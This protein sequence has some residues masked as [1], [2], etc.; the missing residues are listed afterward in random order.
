MV[1]RGVVERVKQRRIGKERTEK[2]SW[3][4]NLN[5]ERIIIDS[6]EGESL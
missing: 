5:E 2:V 3:K 4:G 1:A 6:C